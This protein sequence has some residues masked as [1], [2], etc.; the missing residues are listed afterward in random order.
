LRNGSERPR[1]GCAAE[2]SNEIA[3]PHARP[4]AQ[5][6]ALYRLKRVFPQPARL[7]SLFLLLSATLGGPHTF[8]RNRQFHHSCEDT[9]LIAPQVDASRKRILTLEPT[10]SFVAHPPVQLTPRLISELDVFFS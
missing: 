3:P 8:W 1:H 7:S 10:G 5:E 4:Q 2:K 6:T 9:I